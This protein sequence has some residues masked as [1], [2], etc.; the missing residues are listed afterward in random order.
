MEKKS[1]C[2]FL[3]PTA[4]RWSTMNLAFTLP[5]L[6]SQGYSSLMALEMCMAK[7]LK[8][9]SHETSILSNPMQLEHRWLIKTLGT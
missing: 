9:S 2:Q 8:E 5:H 3:G 6:T 4:G 7:F 1:E